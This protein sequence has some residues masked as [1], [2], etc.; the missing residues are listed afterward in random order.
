MRIANIIMTTYL[1]VNFFCLIQFLTKL[2]YTQFKSSNHADFQSLD[3]YLVHWSN[4]EWT[5]IFQKYE[6]FIYFLEIMILNQSLFLYFPAQFWYNGPR[7][8]VSHWFENRLVHLLEC[9][10][11]WRF[12]D[13]D[14]SV[15]KTILRSNG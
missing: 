1:F 10:Q 4:F 6:L 13:L 9:F 8:R 2:F 15:L 7:M 11:C 14:S 3:E 5:G 12:Q